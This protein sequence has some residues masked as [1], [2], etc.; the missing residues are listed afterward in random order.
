MGKLRFGIL[1]AGNI[2]TKSVAPAILHSNK[3]DLV[4]I[5]SRDQARGQALADSCQCKV[6]RDYD[7]ILQ[8]PDI[9]CIY[10][11]LPN[12][13]HA[14][15]S[16]KAAKN[17][18]HVI[19]EKPAFCSFKEAQQV[20][21]VCK[22]N[23]VRFLEAY[24]FRFHPQHAHVRALIQSGRIGELFH[25]QA[26]FGIPKREPHDFRMSPVFKGGA[27]NDLGGYLISAS[28][29]IFNGEPNHAE[30]ILHIGMKDKVD[31]HGIAQLQFYG[32]Y[33]AQLAF[34]F[35]H[36]YRNEYTIW[37]SKGLVHVNRAFS[38]PPN[39]KPEVSLHNE[40]K[41]EFI[42]I[43][44]ADQF[45]LMIDCFCEAV[46]SPLETDFEMEALLQAQTME[47]IRQSKNKNL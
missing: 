9:D 26:N 7:G 5:A 6:F 39:Y 47:Q 40:N 23:G 3:A 20:L 44:A 15:W 1:G 45:E 46:K 29:L 11:T 33:N 18:K 25:F 13:L 36:F 14:E 12:S 21:E 8:D 28:R 22:H 31:L 32:K 10:I 17:K 30:G 19:C 34:G 43:P 27:F 37:G 35:D 4:A 41:K 2:A 38:I 42:D 24:M 16:L